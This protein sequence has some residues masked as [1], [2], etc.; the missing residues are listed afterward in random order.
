VATEN[1][2]YT[3]FVAEAG[4]YDRN[5]EERN[6]KPATPLPVACLLDQRVSAVPP[7]LG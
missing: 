2:T 3:H 1:R 6:A 4:G 5:D 7:P